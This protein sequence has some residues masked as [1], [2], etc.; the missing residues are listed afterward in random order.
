ML[1]QFLDQ[2]NSARSGCHRVALSRVLAVG[3]ASH[4]GSNHSFVFVHLRKQD[5]CANVPFLNQ[6]RY[7][8]RQNQKLWYQKLTTFP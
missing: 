3:R 5:P 8:L 7:F 6:V 2:K 1:L 4:W